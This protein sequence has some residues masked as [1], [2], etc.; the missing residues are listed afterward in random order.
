MA[1]LSLAVLIATVLPAALC[2]TPCSNPR[3]PPHSVVVAGGYQVGLVA[4]GLSR[5]R[6]LQFDREGHLLVVDAA[7][8]GDPAIVALTLNDNRGACVEEQARK[9]VIRGQ[10]VHRIAFSLCL[11][12]T[13]LLAKSWDC[14]FSGRS[15]FIRVVPRVGVL[16]EV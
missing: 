3:K 8:D 1:F 10:G 6:S 11:V 15:N 12:L 5:P 16:V 9:N 4:T 2:Q 14:S 13:T 7:S